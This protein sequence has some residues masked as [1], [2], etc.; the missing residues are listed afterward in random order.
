MNTPISSLRETLRTKLTSG[1]LRV[2]SAWGYVRS[3]IAHAKRAAQRWYAIQWQRIYGMHHRLS[4]WKARYG[5]VATST[6]LILLVVVSGYLAPTLQ[7]A[8]EP[9]FSDDMRFAGFRTL[10]VTLGGSLIGAT[11]IAFTLVMFAMQVNVERM[12]HGLF[13]KF[14]SDPKLLGAFA[15]TFLLA[16]AIATMSIIPDTS[17]LAV[18]TLTTCWGIVLI[19]VLFLYAY[20]RALCLISPT[21]QLILVVADARRDLQTWVRRARRAAPL[22]EGSDLQNAE[23]ESPLR[24]AHDLPRVTY[25]QLNPHWTAV[26]QKAILY[27][28]SFSRRYAEHGDHEVARVA[29]NAIVAINATYVEAKG[30][31]FF[32]NVLMF[33]N[34]LATDGFINDTLEHLRQNVKIGISRGDEQ[35][36]EQTVRAFVALCRIYLNIDY[37]TEYASKTHAHLAAAY[38]SG[39]VQ[40]VVPHNMPDVLME[41]VRLMGEAGQLMLSKREVNEIATISEKIALISITGVAKEEYRPVT[42][43]GMVQ[44]AKFT[45]ELI[46]GRSSDIHFAAGEIRGDVSLV[47]KLF[48]NIPDTPLSSIHSTY[49][50]PYYSGTSAESLKNWL[51]ELINALANAKADDEAAQRVIRHIEQWADGLYRTEKEIFLAAIQKRSHFTFDI[52]HWIAHVTKLLVAVSNAPAC[53]DHTRE[54]LR[55]SALWLISVLSWVPDEKESVTFVEN[56]DMTETLF[57]AAI[58]A[59]YCGCD[60]VAEQVRKLLFSWA[61]KAGKYETG[62]GIL[63]Q[64]FCGLAT[65]DLVRGQD[66][67]VL[68]AALSVRLAQENAPDQAIRDRAAREIREHAATLHRDRSPLSRIDYAMGRTD[69]GQLRLLL[70]EIANRLSPGTANEPINLDVF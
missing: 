12:P 27:S 68:I 47:T 39:A 21:Q 63:E 42:Q 18:A 54:E 37:A 66:G 58:D 62:W 65:L 35:Q 45:F 32:A 13:R 10:L 9:Y 57:D 14:S 26:A 56:Y 50:A 28:V 22:L 59:H 36:I 1:Q 40:S 7:G 60:E 49:L 16:I 29:L 4:F 38:L 19:L 70:E 30:K 41:G 69:Q 5:A 3:S 64:A 53:N 51:T 48:L 44:L 8:L 6:F 61:F 31:T 24:S 17:W 2:N 67:S 43:I 23:H 55:R 25:F 20:R 15:S 11:A 34:P 46:R 52:V 33:D